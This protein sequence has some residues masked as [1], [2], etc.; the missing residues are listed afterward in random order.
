MKIKD[1]LRDRLYDVASVVC[2]SIIKFPIS[3][4]I[5][6]EGKENIPED[7]YIVGANHSS[8]LDPVFICLGLN[9][10]FYFLAKS[11]KPKSKSE[12]FFLHLYRRFISSFDPIIIPDGKMTRESLRKLLN[13]LDRNRKLV[14]FPEGTRSYDGKLG[15]L[16]KGIAVICDSS[17]KP[18]VP[19]YIKGSFEIWPRTKKFPKPSGRVKLKIGKPIYPDELN[20]KKERR[21]YILDRLEEH[22]RF[23]EAT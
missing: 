16:E 19:L 21:G 4:R 2:K 3:Y 15:K 8:F 1:Y 12:E 10:R 18:I 5:E 23:L 9:E 6:V 14:I 13:L 7:G 20:D 22:L 17:K 11:H